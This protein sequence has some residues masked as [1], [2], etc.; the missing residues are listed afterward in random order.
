MTFFDDLC[1]P[2]ACGKCCMGPGFH[3]SFPR[4]IVPVLDV[5]DILFL[6]VKSHFSDEHST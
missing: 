4:S 3:G 5:F 1:D 2:S 6:N